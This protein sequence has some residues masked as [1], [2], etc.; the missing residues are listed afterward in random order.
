MHYVVVI[1]RRCVVFS[2]SWDVC[3]TSVHLD[4]LPSAIDRLLRPALDFGTVYLSMF[5]LL[6]HTQHFAK[7]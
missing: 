6:H 1:A 4:V 7:S 5:S 2:A 3:L